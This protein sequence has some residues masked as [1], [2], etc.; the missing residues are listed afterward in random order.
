MNKVMIQYYLD[1]KRY[2]ERQRVAVP[3]EGDYVFLNDIIYIVYHVVWMEDVKN[4]PNGLVRVGLRKTDA[5]A[6]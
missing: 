5:T 2:A 1:D 6:Y 4:I 3:R